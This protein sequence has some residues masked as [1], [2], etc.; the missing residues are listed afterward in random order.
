MKHFFRKHVLLLSAVKRRFMSY[1]I[2]CERKGKGGDK[3]LVSL[4]LALI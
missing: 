2:F 3:L 1:S 4:Y